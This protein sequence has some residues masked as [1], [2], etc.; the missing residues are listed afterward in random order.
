[1]DDFYIFQLQSEVSY[2]KELQK[3]FG[4]IFKQGGG[5]TRKK[6]SSEEGIPMEGLFHYVKHPSTLIGNVK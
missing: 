2:I 3:L 4:Y 5:G 6:T 1:M